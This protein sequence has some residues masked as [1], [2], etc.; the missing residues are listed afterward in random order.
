MISFVPGRA[1]EKFSVPAHDSQVPPQ[2]KQPGWSSAQA[3]VRL[4]LLFSIPMRKI[5]A[6]LL[7][8]AVWKGIH[9][10]I[11]WFQVQKED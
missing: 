11:K 2:A 7:V 1:K 10:H 3:M 5:M 4:S 9:S 8:D 6:L